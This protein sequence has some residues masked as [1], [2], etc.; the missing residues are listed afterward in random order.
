MALLIPLYAILVSRI[1]YWIRKDL[2][3]RRINADKG[4]RARAIALA[5]IVDV[6]APIKNLTR[7]LVAPGT[8]LQILE[9]H[10]TRRFELPV[11]TILGFSGDQLVAIPL[12]SF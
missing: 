5:Q 1:T 3:Q 10:P 12:P 6:R 7:L 11:V 4:M 9:S 8:R 2:F